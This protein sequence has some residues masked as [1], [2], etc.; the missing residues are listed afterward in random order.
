[1]PLALLP[2]ASETDQRRELLVNQEKKQLCDLWSAT[3]DRS[4][5]IQYVVNILQPNTD[6]KHVASTAGKYLSGAVSSVLTAAPQLAGASVFTKAGAQLTGATL[7]SI[8]DKS[9][10]DSRRK[11]GITEQEMT[12]LY[13]MVRDSADR[14]VDGYRNYKLALTEYDS[15]VEEMED[16]QTI[17]ANYSDLDAAHALMDYQ[18][19]LRRCLRD[20]QVREEKVEL[21]RQQLIDL[22]GTTAVADLDSQ[23]LETRLMLAK[24]GAPIGRRLLIARPTSAKQ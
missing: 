15:K 19:E 7:N 14:L 23:I 3:I 1:V 22:A 13:K 24:L 21:H 10:A 2:D 18:F 8:F 12:L 6:R 4:P 9:Q 17:I 11:A 16:L 20:V 5:D